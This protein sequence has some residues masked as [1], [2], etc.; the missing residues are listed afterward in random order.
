MDQREKILQIVRMKG[1]VLPSQ[2]NKEI[3]TDVLFASAMLSEL[4]D[5]R[6]LFLSNTKIGGSPVYYAKGQEYK[7]Q[8]LYNN[9]HEKEKMAYDVLK[10]EGVLEDLKQQPVIRAALR[11][12]RDFAKPMDVSFNNESKLFWKWYLLNDEETNSRIKSTLGISEEKIEKENPE[13][14]KEEQEDK[15]KLIQKLVEKIE[16][17]GKERKKESREEKK[18]DSIK[19]EAEEKPPFV[20]TTVSDP[21]IKK[22]KDFFSKNNIQVLDYRLIRKNSEADFVI[23]VPSSVGS[24][25][26][27][28]KAKSKKKV[29]DGDLS[30][31]YIQSQI[32]KLPILFLTEGEL[33]KKANELLATEFKNMTVKKI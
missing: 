27:Y 19:E 8:K 1:P 21:F 30:S 28:C 11:E 33:S 29:N 4:V 13:V 18:E 22:I 10:K 32:K 23:N 5:K 17:E 15:E 9:L 7:L 3:G 16:R 24:L 6:L 2:I 31:A 20:D 25:S 14:K 26:Y 12:I